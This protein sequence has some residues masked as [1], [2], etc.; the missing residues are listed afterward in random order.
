M[1]LADADLGRM[2]APCPAEQVDLSQVRVS[3]RFGLE[4]G[5]RP[6]GTQKIRCVDSCTESG[7]NPCTEATEH[8]TTDGL[9][10]LFA[11]MQRV[12]LDFGVVPHPFKEDIDSAYRRVPVLPEHR[13]AAHVAF[14]HGDTVQVA[15]HLAM[16]FGAS[17]SVYAWDRV[18]SALIHIVRTLLKIP[19]GKYV[20]DFHGAERPEC[21]EHCKCCVERVI[22]AILGPTSVSPAKTDWGLPMDDL[23]GAT[24]DA[25]HYGVTFWPNEKKVVKWAKQLKEILEAKRLTPGAA[26]KIAGKLSWSAQIVFCRLGRA[27]IRALYNMPRGCTWNWQVESTLKWWLEV[28]QL[29]IYQIRPWSMP[30]TRPV[31]VFCDARSTPPRLSAVIYTGDGLSFYTD[32]VPPTALLNMFKDRSDGQICSLELC[33]IALALCTFHQLCGDQK[34]RLWSDNR[35]SENATRKGSAREWDHNHVV[36][37]IWVKAASIRC[38]RRIDRVPTKDNIADLPSREEYRLLHAMETVFMEP[39]LDEMFWTEA[40]WDTVMLQNMLCR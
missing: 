29:Q 16:P 26:K 17:S 24:I 36:H 28:F 14:K 39:K 1:T 31:Q 35:G 40:A 23:L 5:L 4:Q 12:W 8:L 9:D 15:G 32:M 10:H 33:A 2:T 6:D 19:V 34:V 11:V 7:I 25:D 27:L 18:G 13:W 38:H 22:K 20:D 21:I 3:K 30:D 37:S